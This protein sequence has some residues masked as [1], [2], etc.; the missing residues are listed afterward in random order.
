[1]D[2]ETTR[3]RVTR[4]SRDFADQ[5]DSHSAQL[6]G[7]QSTLEEL[8]NEIA[9][10]RGDITGLTNAFKSLKSEQVLLGNR[11]ENALSAS[12]RTNIRLDEFEDHPPA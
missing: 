4:L 1:M 3:A 7:I 5:A 8:Q 2:D 11:V 12:R 6:R 9:A 10:M